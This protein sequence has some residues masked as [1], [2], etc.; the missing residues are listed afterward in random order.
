MMRRSFVAVVVGLLLLVAPSS[1]R[2][3]PD[4]GAPGAPRGFGLT[5]RG[6]TGYPFVAGASLGVEV[7]PTSTLALEA[8]LGGVGS[9]ERQKEEGGTEIM[10]GVRWFPSSMVGAPRLYLLGGAHLRTVA[11]TFG[12]DV[13]VARAFF[14]GYGGLG[15]DVP[16]NDTFALRGELMGSATPRL[17]VSEPDQGDSMRAQVRLQLGVTAY[18]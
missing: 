14:G 4:E 10:A 8:A 5:L 17:A 11:G 3:E 6:I 2:A 16:L 18:F 13:S 1:A 9:L 12:G 7:N 15:L